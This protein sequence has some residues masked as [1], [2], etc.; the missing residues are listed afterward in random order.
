MHVRARLVVLALFALFMPSAAT[1]QEA[2]APKAASAAGPT[3]DGTATAFRAVATVDDGSMIELQ[4]RQGVGRPVALMIVGGA[5]LL[6]G[7]VIGDDVGTLF[8][9]GGAVALLYG[10]YKYLQ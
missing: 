4:R 9:I 3:L 5:A 8:M 7:A 1:A 10:L 6:V 2:A